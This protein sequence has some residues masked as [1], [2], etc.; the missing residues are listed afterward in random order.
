MTSRAH[1]RTRTCTNMSTA[2]HVHRGSSAARCSAGGA[3]CSNERAWRR[4]D[5]NGHDAHTLT[6]SFCRDPGSEQRHRDVDDVRATA[7]RSQGRQHGVTGSA[8]TFFRLP[9]SRG[10]TLSAITTRQA[11]EALLSHLAHCRTCRSGCV[12]GNVGSRRLQLSKE[13]G[14]SQPLGWGSTVRMDHVAARYLHASLL[15]RE[16]LES[17]ELPHLPLD[18]LAR[19]LRLHLHNTRPPFSNS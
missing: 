14:A 11:A 2:V 18:M 16:P 1:T 5:C 3:S 6:L 15:R 12:S 8:C 10:C 4:F 7:C 9:R 13:E 17:G 19:A